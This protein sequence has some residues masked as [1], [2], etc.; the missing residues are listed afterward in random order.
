[1]KKKGNVCEYTQERDEALCREF[2]RCIG[3]AKFINLPE[4]FRKVASAPAGRYYVSEQRAF[5]V[6]SQWKSSGRLQVNSPMRRRMFEDI[7]R[8]AERRR[9][10]N[11]G[12]SLY[13]AIFE[14][15]NSPAPSFYL[16]PGSART[17]IYRSLDN[18]Y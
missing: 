9:R 11:S 13:D 3:E 6:I 1:M 15:V 14:T 2:R 17:I 12:M 16:T 4:I 5:L 8:E 18:G 7:A 10:A